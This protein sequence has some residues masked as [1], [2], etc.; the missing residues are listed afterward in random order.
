MCT[1]LYLFIQPCL[2][3]PDIDEHCKCDA[4][5][6]D[7]ILG[8]VS[9]DK[10]G[11]LDVLGAARVVCLEVFYCLISNITNYLLF[12]VVLVDRSPG[13]GRVSSRQQFLLDLLY[14]TVSCFL[15]GTVAIFVVL[16][17][18]G[19]WGLISLL[20]LEDVPLVEFMYLVF[21]RMPCES[22]RRRLR[23]FLLYLCY[24]FPAQIN[25]LVCCGFA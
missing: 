21:T 22:Y 20:E 9:V 16:N 13:G 24:V 3:E 6:Q 11:A 2:F 10:G 1:V 23:S 17:S 5:T 14:N 19:F 4:P 7:P 8:I 15:R 25:S 12:Y 18:I